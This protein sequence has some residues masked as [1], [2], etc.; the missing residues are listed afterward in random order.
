MAFIN[1]FRL[2]AIAAVGLIGGVALAA[3]QTCPTAPIGTP[4]FSPDFSMNPPCLAFNSTNSGGLTGSPSIAAPQTAQSSVASV[5]RLTAAESGWATSAWYQAPQVVANGFSTTFAFQI[6]NSS[7]YPADG[8]AFV[9]QNNGTSSLSELGTGGCGIGFGSSNL[10]TSGTGIPNS[11][12]I[13][14]NT[15]NNGTGVDP[16]ANDVTIQNCGGNAANLVDSSCSLATNDLSATGQINLSDGSVHVATVTY[17]TSTLSNCGGSRNQSCSTLDVVLDGTD[18][19]PGGVLFDMTTISTS[20]A[21]VGFTA[22]TGGGNDEQD[23]VSWTFTPA[24]QSQTGTIT[25]NP[26]AP[27][28][29][30][31]NGGFAIN[32]PTSGYDF[33]AQQTP[34]SNQTLQMV[35]T[36]VPM[37]M[38][39]CN[40]LVQAHTP[41]PTAQCFVYQ[42]GGGLYQDSA[43][44]FEVTCPPTGSCGSSASPFFADLGTDF[45]F[46]CLKNVPLQCGPPDQ[47][48][49]SF[50][51]PHLTPTDGLPSVGFLKG[52]GPDAIHPCTPFSDSITPLFTSNQ[53]E[54]FHLGDTS[55]GAKGGSGGTTSCWVMTYQTQNETPTISITQPVNG[56]S[57][58]LGESDGTTAASYSCSA[59]S[60]AAGSPTGPYLTIPAGSCAATDT[61]G[62]AV[63]NGS[64]F[65]TS[66]LGLHTFT[67]QVQDSATNTNQQSVTYSVVSPP[68]ISGPS[69]ATFALGSAGSAIFSATGYPIPTFTELGALPSGITFV[70][71]HNGTAT[72]GGTATTSGIYSITITAQNGAGS[73][74]TLAFTLTAAGSAPA[75]GKCNGV[76]NGTFKGNLTISAGQTCKFVGGG[77]TGNVTETGGAFVATNAALGG[78]VVVSGGTFS[79]GPAVSIKGNFSVLIPGKSTVQSQ[80]CGAT[81]GGNV[82]VLGSGTPVTIG[83]SSASCPGNIITGTLT[84]SAN[85]AATAIY[86][87]TVGGG[88]LDL[89]NLKPTQVFSNHVRGA[90][91][92]AADVSI[93]GGGNIAASKQ[94]QCAKF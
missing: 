80:V 6:G 46:D 65:D 7:T 68:T 67:V 36:T 19:F 16:S 58:S 60:A 5:L 8:I 33:T 37:S 22:G 2:A 81:I 57:Y 1:S 90:L 52:E 92:C 31:Y 87:N 53:I 62:S 27:T 24:G 41:F 35:V 26:T 76:Y 74:A 14:F 91:N 48:T 44:M 79:V 54:D 50:G 84:V 73:P 88:L 45:S 29:F 75:A 64:Q 51:L 12:A 43:V 55:G 28:T 25:P 17:T 47:P 89:A 59:V 49:L 71:N 72:L 85:F 38:A 34:A 32:D 42:N 70:D 39:A 83:S 40:A 13:E 18:L 30:T 77:I 20:S 82:Q 63:A 94:G 66:T 78:N 10:C 4:S 23:I 15:F 93:T 9:I 69:S 86:N 3:A 21:F 11:V 61:P 56:H